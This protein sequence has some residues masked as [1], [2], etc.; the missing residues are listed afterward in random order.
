EFTGEI[1]HHAIEREYQR[2]H[3]MVNVSST[4]SVDKAVLEAMACGLPVITANEAFDA[5]LRDWR[6]LA[7]V[8]PDAPD[9]LAAKIRHIMALPADTRRALGH[10][11]RAVVVR[12]HSLERLAD[13]LVALLGA[14]R[15]PR[16]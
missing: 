14:Q 2:A 16:P 15:R 7:L 13:Q 3:L 9:I 10:D 5:I 1:P 12:D 8:P 4:G 11:L 6:D